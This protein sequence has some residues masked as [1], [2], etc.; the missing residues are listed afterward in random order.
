MGAFGL[1]TWRGW[2]LFGGGEGGGG[3]MVASGLGGDG[4]G[5]GT[6]AG[7]VGE[8]GGEGRWRCPILKSSEREELNS[9]IPQLQQCH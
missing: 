2:N 5:G 9:G 7:G 3:G 6:V 4:G 1:E 8:G